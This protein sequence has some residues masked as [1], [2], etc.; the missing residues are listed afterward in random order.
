ML[1]HIT[2]LFAPFARLLKVQEYNMLLNRAEAAE[3]RLIPDL[4][5]SFLPPF[6]CP[7]CLE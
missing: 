4:H 2:F 5:C 3:A 1:W 7:I 6:S